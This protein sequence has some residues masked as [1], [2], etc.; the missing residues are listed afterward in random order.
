[1]LQAHPLHLWDACNGCLRCTYR[2]YDAVDE[3]TAATS[4]AFSPDGSR[5][6]GGF[7]RAIRVW[8]TDRPGRDYRE[9]VTHRK[10]EEGLPGAF[11]VLAQD[12]GWIGLGFRA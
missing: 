2:A 8:Q 9:L 1:M 6:F 10:G 4:V 7:N 3:V 11:H 5:L 12:L